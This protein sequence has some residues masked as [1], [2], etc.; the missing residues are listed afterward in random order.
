MPNMPHSYQLAETMSNL[1]LLGGNFNLYS[2]KKKTTSVSK[3][4]VTLSDA[5]FATS[6]LV[7]TVCQSPTRRSLSLYQLSK[8][9]QH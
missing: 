1:G 4:W 8:I 2:N 9:V 3:Q 5:A 7:C 6:Y